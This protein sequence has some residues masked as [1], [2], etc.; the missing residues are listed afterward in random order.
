M[1]HAIREF[2]RMGLDRG[3]I[4]GEARA[5]RH[6]LQDLLDQIRRISPEL[7]TKRRIRKREGADRL[8]ENFA[9]LAPKVA[10]VLAAE[11]R[12]VEAEFQTHVDQVRRY[13]DLIDGRERRR[14]LPEHRIG[15]R[16]DLALAYVRRIRHVYSRLNHRR[17]LAHSIIDE[18]NVQLEA[19][20]LI[21]REKLPEALRLGEEAFDVG[22]GNKTAQS[23][24]ALLCAAAAYECFEESID[25]GR[26]Y[27]KLA[28][29]WAERAKVHAA[30]TE[31]AIEGRATVWIGVTRFVDA[32]PDRR[33]AEACRDEV[34]ATLRRF[35]GGALQ[36]EFERLRRMLDSE[37]AGEGLEVINW[38]HNPRASGWSLDKLVAEIVRRAWKE[39]GSIPQFKKLLQLKSSNKA[40][41]LMKLAGIAKCESPRREKPAGVKVEKRAS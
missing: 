41:G 14:S 6:R 21:D 28:K 7:E 19:G 9:K 30:N 17:G 8:L 40:D 1:L 18:G 3:P 24:A 10:K 11:Q 2:R 15:R 35:P 37:G 4:P 25:D 32:T 39:T 12:P 33:T 29:E 31:P 26:D 20:R 38:F 23:R 27:G 5:M 36:R 34:I 22:H 16:T 13:L